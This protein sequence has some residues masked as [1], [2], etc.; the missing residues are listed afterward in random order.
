VKRRLTEESVLFISVLKWFVLATIVGGIVGLST[1]G[2]LKVLNWST[3]FMNQYSYSFLFLPG[4]LLLSAVLIRY[5]APDA[6]G[7]GTDRVIEAVH[8]R[9]GKIKGMVVPVKLAATVITIATGG[10]AG[11]IGPCAQIGGG[12]TSLFADLF[13]FDDRDRKKLVI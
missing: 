8:K 5:L 12:L 10:S 11:R 7:Q 3:A 13:R 1:T 4:A 9:S 6:A 2:F